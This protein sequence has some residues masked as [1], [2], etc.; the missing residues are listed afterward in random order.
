MEAH[1][2][3]QLKA[4][5]ASISTLVTTQSPLPNDFMF[6]LC[7]TVTIKVTKQDKLYFSPASAVDYKNFGMIINRWKK[8]NRNSIL[9]TF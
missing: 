6:I 4:F 7:N 2:V 1:F 5:F 8:S 9:F 3:A